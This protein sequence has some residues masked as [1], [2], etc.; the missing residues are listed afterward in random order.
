MPF[1]SKKGQKFSACGRHL[2]YCVQKERL[3]ALFQSN[4]GQKVLP[5]A[6]TYIMVNW[7]REA[8]GAFSKSQ[9][10][11]WPKL[12]KCL[13]SKRC[14]LNYGVEGG[15]PPLSLKSD[16]L[17]PHGPKAHPLLEAGRLVYC[18]AHPTYTPLFFCPGV[19][20]NL[21][22]VPFIRLYNFYTYTMILKILKHCSIQGSKFNL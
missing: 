2:Y 19:Q 13:F 7:Q 15:I 5:A 22:F 8:E 4:K 17:P 18:A 16:T 6:G 14:L 12:H 20:Q 10:K 11:S 21:G 1:Q 9:E 3:R